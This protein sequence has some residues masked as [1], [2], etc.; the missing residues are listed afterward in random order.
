MA[1]LEPRP[2][3]CWIS[4]T[5]C[6]RCALTI[7]GLGADGEGDAGDAGQVVAEAEVWPAVEERGELRV[8]AEAEFQGEQAAGAERGVGLRDEAAVDVEAIGAGEEGGVGFEVADFALQGRGVRLRDVG[9][10]GDDGVE[11]MCGGGQR[12]EEIG[13]Q[14][15]QA[16]GIAEARGVALGDGEGGGGEVRRGDGGVGKVRGDGE[17]DGS[18]AGADVEEAHWRSGFGEAASPGEDGFDEELGFGARDQDRGRDVEVEA[19]KLLVADDVLER[20]AGGAAGD[21]TVEG[22]ELVCAERGF[23]VGEEPGAVLAEQVEQ[24]GFGVAAGV[25]T[26]EDARGCGDGRAKIHEGR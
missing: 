8:L 11:G 26:V 21:E 17:G 1:R 23:G 16:R 6:E 4:S 20:L 9:R 5:G 24:Q 2:C 15:R 12:G 3:R 7:P 18:G 10:V 25:N 14:E 19:V 13:L 22:G